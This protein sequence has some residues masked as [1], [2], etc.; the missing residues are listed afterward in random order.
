MI[1]PF[2]HLYYQRSAALWQDLQRSTN[3]VSL[4][5][6]QLEDFTC[7]AGNGVRSLSSVRPVHRHEHI[8]L[9]NSH[10]GQQPL[11]KS[12]TFQRPSRLAGNVR[13]TLTGCCS[14]SF[15]EDT[16]TYTQSKYCMSGNS[17]VLSSTRKGEVESEEGGNFVTT[18]EKGWK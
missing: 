8:T 2:Q 14:H 18:R 4:L 9:H 10:W 16:H 6:P 13:Q 3:A 15:K 17:G 11:S 1:S 5:Q 12:R 7:P